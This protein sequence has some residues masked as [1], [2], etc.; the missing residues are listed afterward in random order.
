MYPD[1]A[2]SA[3]IAVL[4]I[5][6][7]ILATATTPCQPGMPFSQLTAACTSSTSMF[8][9]LTLICSLQ[10]YCG[11]AALGEQAYDVRAARVLPFGQ[12]LVLS[13]YLINLPQEVNLFWTKG[14]SGVTILFLMN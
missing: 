7:N 11:F 3:T 8:T 13:E 5:I 6:Y 14:W 1:V 10:N 2:A 12:A 4:T 9:R